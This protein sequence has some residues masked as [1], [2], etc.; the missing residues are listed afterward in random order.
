MLIAQDAAA[1]SLR[2]LATGIPASAIVDVPT[3]LAAAHT[4]HRQM[5]INDGDYKALGIPIKFSR[6]PGSVRSKP[7]DLGTETRDVCRSIG[8]SDDDIDAMIARGVVF[9]RSE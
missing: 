8:F 3:A 2:L 4:A 1:F 7:Q 6:T 5:I 9:E